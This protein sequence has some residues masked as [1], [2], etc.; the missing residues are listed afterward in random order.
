M[1]ACGRGRSRRWRAARAGRAPRTP[2]PPSTRTSCARHAAARARR[3]AA[4][5]GAATRRTGAA[6]ARG[7]GEPAPTEPFDRLAV[8]LLGR[9][10]PRS[11]APARAPRR[12]ARDRSPPPGSARPAAPSRR[13]ELA[14]RP[15]QPP[16]RARAA[17]T[18][19]ASARRARSRSGPGRAPPRAA[20]RP[21]W[22]RARA[23][24]PKVSTT[25]SLRATAAASLASISAAPAVLVP[26]AP[27]EQ[28]PSEDDRRGAGRLRDLVG[29]V[30]QRRGR[31]QLA[32]EAA[33]QREHVER[34][35]QDGERAG[36]AGDLDVA[37]GER[38]PRVVVEQVRRDAPGDPGPAHV[39]LAWPPSS[40]TAASAR[41]SAGALAA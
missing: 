14:C 31:G 24:S 11:P 34:E 6:R 18:P 22:S 27:G 1:S 40:R 19:T 12:R 29:L 32:F 23:C 41:L 15:V 13:R 17:T 21:L 30:E 39:L 3:R 2:R 5:P 37:R 16:R 20:P 38:V 4:A 35:R 25:P 10:R 28:D 8:Q 33:Q 26:P 7:R 9:R 36:V